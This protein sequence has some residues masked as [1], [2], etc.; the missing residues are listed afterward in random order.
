MAGSLKA[1]ALYVPTDIVSTLV[2]QGIEPKPGGEIRE[3][4]VLFADLPGFTTLTEEHGV[5][6]APFLTE[7]LT[8]ATQIIHAEGG[9]VDKFIGDCI[10]GLWNAPAPCSDHALRACRAA[11]AIRDAMQTVG[12]PDGREHGPRVR[13][14]V[15]TGQALVGN[16]GSD[17][18]LSYTAIGDVVNVASRLEALGK[19]F[20]TEILVSAATRE[21]AGG[22]MPFKPLG[23]SQVKGRDGA[24]QIFELAA[25]G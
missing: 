13:I 16:V 1:F 14:G 25:C 6:V 18:R 5:N 3:I 17:E 22:S 19:E 7:F 9:T 21:A 2:Q 24:V 15:N 10:M 4:T 12:R 23:A 20:G 11:A 8:L